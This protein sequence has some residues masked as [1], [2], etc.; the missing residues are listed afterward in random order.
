M[1]S[2][3]IVV[4]ALNEEEKI[5]HTVESLLPACRAGLE[6]FELL[7]VNDGS[8]D[9]TGEVM[10]RLARETPEI[11][12]IHHPERRGVGV[13]YRSGIEQAR[14]DYVTLVPGDNIVDPMTW[15]PMFGVLG[16]SDIIVGCRVN[17]R[18]N[19]SW[20]R[21]LISRS[22]SN[23]MC[24]L[25]SIRLS[26]FQGLVIYPTRMVRELD[27]KSTGYMYQMEFLVQL[28]RRGC[29]I[30]ETPFTMLPE[31]LRSGRS[32][33]FST[34]VDMFRT[35]RRLRKVRR[36]ASTSGSGSLSAAPAKPVE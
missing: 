17:Q 25:H 30:A 36:S 22:F 18:T 24:W 32:L 33:R 8:T 29:S 3:S 2:L 19:R 6:R 27:L 14:M 31:K 12:V 34:I 26:D 28:H 23:F 1:K 35:W 16:K 9:R 5:V 10:E 4:P 15:G 11:V 21:Y 7:L 13:A 20:I